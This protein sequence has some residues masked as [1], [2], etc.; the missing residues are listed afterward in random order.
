MRNRFADHLT[1]GIAGENIF[2]DV[3]A[4]LATFANAKQ[5][6]IQHGGETIE[7]FEV[8]PA[9]PCEPFST[10]CLVVPQSRA[11]IKAALQ[12]LSNGVRGYYAL[13]ADDAVAFSVQAGDTLYVK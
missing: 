10:F 4:D 3:E 5:Y 8:I 13:L 12:F 2:V 9:P 11:E 1:D 6:F 7:L